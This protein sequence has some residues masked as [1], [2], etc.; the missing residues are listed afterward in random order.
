MLNILVT[1]ST[2]RVTILTLQNLELIGHKDQLL[3]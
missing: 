1:L 3:N 2:D